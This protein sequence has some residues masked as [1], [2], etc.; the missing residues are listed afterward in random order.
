MEIDTLSVQATS[1]VVDGTAFTG[2]AG[3]TIDG[4]LAFSSTLVTILGRSDDISV[5]AFTLGSGNVSV[6]S[7]GVTIIGDGR[8]PSSV[9]PLRAHMS[10]EA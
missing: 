10:Q 9:L 1:L 7:G 5:R 4:A 6:T 2:G 3:V 8:F